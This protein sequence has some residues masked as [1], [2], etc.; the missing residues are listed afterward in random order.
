MVQDLRH[1]FRT[2]SKSPTFTS[3]AVLTLGF[4]IGA[5]AAIFSIVSGL[6][7]RPLP[8]VEADRLALLSTP[9]SASYRPPFSF[10]MLEHL[11]QHAR[12]LDGA[13]AFTTCCGTAAVAVGHTRY[14]VNRQFVSGDFFETLGIHAFRGRVLTRADNDVNPP[15]GPVAAISYAFWRRIGSPDNIRHLTVAVDDVPF[16]IVGVTPPSFFGVE[17]GR[18]FDI[19]VPLRLNA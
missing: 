12:T 19:T 15:D 7:L 13:L 18:A 4:G 16:T 5:N 2:L 10:A 9:T 3:V 6:L 14:D 17:V 8:V 11:E 1:A